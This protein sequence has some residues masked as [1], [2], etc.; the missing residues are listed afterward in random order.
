M[1]GTA[2]GGTVT[3]APERPRT[4]RTIRYSFRSMVTDAPAGRSATDVRD[5][6]V[7]DTAVGAFGPSPPGWQSPGW[8]PL[9]W[10]PGSEPLGREQPTPVT[11]TSV[12]VIVA[13]ATSRTGPADAEVVVFTVDDGQTVTFDLRSASPH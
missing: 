7:G 13:P 8:Q 6:L 9:G 2:G 10:P 12:T 3:A 11:T 4:T 5:V 1:S